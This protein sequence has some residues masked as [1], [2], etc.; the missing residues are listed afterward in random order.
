[1]AL[2]RID[3]QAL[4]TP[5]YRQALRDVTISYNRQ[6]L[7]DITNT[8]TSLNNVVWPTKP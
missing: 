1:M 5:D 7:R 2:T 4:F 8:Y 6:A 3:N